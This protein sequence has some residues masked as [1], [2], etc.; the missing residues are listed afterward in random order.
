MDDCT[1]CMVIAEK[2]YLERTEHGVVIKPDNSLGDGHLVVAPLTHLRSFAQ[3]P[4]IAAQVMRLAAMKAVEPCAVVWPLGVP[5]RQL[6][7]HIYA[8]IIP[9]H[10]A[11]VQ[12]IPTGEMLSERGKARNGSR[13]VR[14]RGHVQ[15][16]AEPDGGAG[17]AGG[18]A[19]VPGLDDPEAASDARGSLP[20]V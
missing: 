12:A 15:G 2:R 14:G 17:A 9:A 18:A 11:V 20:S 5:A 8:Q 19:G 1:I 3:N 10:L 13:A 6:I 7:P 4:V 16:D